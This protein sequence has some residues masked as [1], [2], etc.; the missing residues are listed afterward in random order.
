M[1]HVPE[2]LNGIQGSGRQ[3]QA[4]KAGGT[5]LLKEEKGKRASVGREFSVDV[6]MGRLKWV[7]AEKGREWGRVKR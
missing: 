4:R 6:L 1:E 2:E 5:P 7:A 3:D